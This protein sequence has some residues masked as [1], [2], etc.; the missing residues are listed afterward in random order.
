MTRTA[1]PKRANS[2]PLQEMCIRDRTTV[3]QAF[4]YY[5]NAEI[6][7][8][9]GDDGVRYGHRRGAVDNYVVVA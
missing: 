1:G 4:P 5:I 2:L 3:E 9:V 8:T 6:C 7:Q